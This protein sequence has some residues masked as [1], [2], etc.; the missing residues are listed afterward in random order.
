MI[1][2]EKLLKEAKISYLNDVL[3]DWKYGKI[4]ESIVRHVFNVLIDANAEGFTELI[5]KVTY[6][7]CDNYF[8]CRI[9]EDMTETDKSL[10]KDLED[11]TLRR[12]LYE[13]GMV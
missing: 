9:P 1:T 4:N 7:D 10:L 2:A 5:N 11:I 6:G 13:T 12:H 3:Y 8:I